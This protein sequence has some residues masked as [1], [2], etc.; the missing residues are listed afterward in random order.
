MTLIT[1]TAQELAACTPSNSAQGAHNCTKVVPFYPLRYAVQPFDGG[2]SAYEHA[3]LEHKKFPALR[4]MRYVL[5][6]LR[7]DDGYLYIYDPLN[8]EQI[9]CFVYRSPDD[10]TNGGQQ[11]PAQFQRLALTPQ[12]KPI[13]LAGKPLSFPYIPAYDH[14][15]AHVVIWFADTMQTP[16][17]LKAFKNDTNGIRTQLGTPVDLG[18]W[19]TAFRKSA[20]PAQAPMVKHTIRLEDIVD[21]HAVGVDSKPVPWSEYREGAQLPTAAEMSMAQGPDSARLAVVLYDAVG[22]MSELNQR[23]GQVLNGWGEYNAKSQRGLWASAAVDAVLSQAASKAYNSLVDNDP[24]GSAV[25]GTGATGGAVLE[26]QGRAQAAANAAKARR[27]AFL[28][29]NDQKRQAFL[30]SDKNTRKEWQD[31]LDKAAAMLWAWWNYTGDGSWAPSL[32]HY[33]TRE[34]FNFRAMRGAVSRCILGLACHNEGANALAKQLLPEGPTGVLY[35][36]MQGFPGQ[37]EYI[38]STRKTISVVGD[39]DASKAMEKLGE[40]LQKIPADS[41]SQELAR[42]I[43]A[44]LL[45]NG[46]L[47]AGEAFPGTRYARMLEMLDGNLL[48]RQP[49]PLSQVPDVLRKDAKIEGKTPFRRLKTARTKISEAVEK[50][51]DLYRVKAYEPKAAQSPEVVKGLSGRLSLWHKIK[52]GAGALGVYVAADN[53]LNAVNELGSDGLTLATALDI[54]TNA[55]AMVSSGAAM[56]SAMLAVTQ[57]RDSLAAG[58][59]V[60]DVKIEAVANFADRLAIGAAGVAGFLGGIKSTRDAMSQHGEVMAASIVSATVQF[61]EFGIAAAYLYG[62]QLAKTFGIRAFATF[63]EVEAGPVGWAILSFDILNTLIAA[64]IKQQVAEQNINDWLD[65]CFWGKHPQFP[66][67]DTERLAFARL[68]QEPYIESDRHITEKLATVAIPGIGPILSTQL[69]AR[70]MTVVFPGWHPQIGAYEITQYKE[71]NALGVEQ[72]L[73][74]PGK[75]VMRGND[76]YLTFNTQTQIGGTAVIYWPNGFS[77]PAVHFELPRNQGK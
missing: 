12:F 17:K 18:P 53:L 28:A 10:G 4:G 7:D 49:T 66:N 3:N 44:L 43:Q 65:H 54:G 36:A 1:K 14:N 46:I 21:Q 5:R 61:S 30:S 41:A 15:P 40:L 74:D 19:F 13:E 34:S 71:F 25:K 35:Y 9:I 29:G 23:I 2:G 47:R 73:N 75:V 50:E 8:R 63:A 6:G 68:S 57:Q 51:V 11:R 52:L 67:M 64:Y 39:R 55:A 33:D 58:K 76:G 38:D 26:V 37:T 32:A 60:K 48:L 56:R 59:A 20:H 31:E 22:I 45:K 62:Q 16:D 77:D 72:S 27:C 42:V 70:T 24:V 69:P